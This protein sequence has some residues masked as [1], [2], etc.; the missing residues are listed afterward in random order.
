MGKTIAQK[1]I[2]SHLVSGD[3]T[4]GSEVALRIDQTLT[5]DATG[6]MAYLE[7][8]TMGIPRVKTEMSIAYVDHNTLQCGFENSR[9]SPL[10][11][12]RYR[13][14]RRVFLPP[15]QRHLPSG[16]SGAFRQARQDPH[17]F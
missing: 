4:P 12:D 6:T 7:F 17:R 11:A 13:Q 3:M 2:A 5:Q 1:I 8:E 16:A 10:F 14:A 9:R 15:R